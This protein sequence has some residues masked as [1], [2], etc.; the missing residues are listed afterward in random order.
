MR[1]LP[2]SSAVTFTYTCDLGEDVKP[3][4][5]LAKGSGAVRH[6]GDGKRPAQCLPLAHPPFSLSVSFP[7]SGEKAVDEGP[8]PFA[9][10]GEGGAIGHP[11]GRPSFGRAMGAEEGWRRKARLRR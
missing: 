3:R 6:L 1:R 2:S 10:Y 11:E 9:S 7:A 5:A 8:G 4:C